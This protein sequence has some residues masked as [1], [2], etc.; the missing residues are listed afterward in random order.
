[1]CAINTRG[2]WLRMRY[3]YFI[4]FCSW[5][6]RSGMHS[7]T[8][9]DTTVTF[10]YRLSQMFCGIICWCSASLLCRTCEAGACRLSW[11]PSLDLHTVYIPKPSPAGQVRD[12][13]DAALIA[14]YWHL[15]LPS[16]CFEEL[17]A[18]PDG[19]A[20]GET[21]SRRASVWIVEWLTEC[22]D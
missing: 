8:I 16:H 12:V 14:R 19:N 21:A 7:P 22:H 2:I 6:M 5:C 13:R 15:L 10:R 1:V 20:C 3:C 18:Q 11:W 9:T 4:A 17:P